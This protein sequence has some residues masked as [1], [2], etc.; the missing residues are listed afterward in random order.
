M[1]KIM[2]ITM[3]TIAVLTAIVLVAMTTTAVLIIISMIQDIR[4]KTI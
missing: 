4:R 3:M 1:S 2:S